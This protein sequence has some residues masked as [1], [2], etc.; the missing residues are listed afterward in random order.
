ME[1]LANLLRYASPV[2]LGALGETVGQK[3]GVI[4]IGLEGQ[5]LTAAFAATYAS[6]HSHSGWVGLAA[7]V[8]AGLA[9]GLVQS[10]FTLR[11]AADQVVVGT[12]M[13]LFALGLTSALFRTAFGQGGQLLSL[14][15]LGRLVGPF[16][17][18][19]LTLPVL[20][21]LVT[22]AL[23]R[24]R[25]GLAL[26]AAGEFPPAVESAGFS[27]LRL[28]LIASV[29]GGLFAG[30]AGGYLALGSAGSFAENMTAGRGFV[31]IAMVTFG[32]WKPGWVF[33]ACLLV[34]AAEL[35]QFTLQAQ[36]LPVPWIFAL[37]SW[38]PRN[39]PPVAGR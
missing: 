12:A 21:V 29:V 27:V 16:D 26:R 36:N 17:A 24:T 31:A 23:F 6:V 1:L 13:N 15:A 38:S 35:S 37:T 22:L 39:S 4:N 9:Y 34:G 30:L 7:G 2:C 11:L 18:V 33:G 8:A 3:A 28:R 10:L 5:M 32:R 14:P 20:V 19:E 25:F